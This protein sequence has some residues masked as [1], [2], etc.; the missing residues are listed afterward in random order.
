MPKIFLKCYT[1]KNYAE[2]QINR[3][4]SNHIWK[5]QYSK[6][7]IKQAVLQIDNLANTKKFVDSYIYTFKNP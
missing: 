1:V 7:H 5:F 6:C 2:I 4:R 3:N